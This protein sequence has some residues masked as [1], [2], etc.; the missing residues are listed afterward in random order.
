[1]C[2]YRVSTK[3]IN[4][5]LNNDILNVPSG[6]CICLC[7]PLCYLDFLLSPRLTFS[8][9]CAIRLRLRSLYS[10]LKSISFFPRPCNCDSSI[11]QLSIR[12]C[13]VPSKRSLQPLARPRALCCCICS[14]HRQIS[15][16]LI[17]FICAAR[18]Y[19]CSKI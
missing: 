13:S 4:S 2:V 8:L 19:V 3:Y 11:T 18:N 6:S 14:L 15:F 5:A 10:P 1:M 12:R 7:P 16:T 9:N 17:T